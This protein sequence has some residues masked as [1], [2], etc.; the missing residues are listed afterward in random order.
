MPCDPRYLS[1]FCLSSL[2]IDLISGVRVVASPAASPGHR[3]EAKESLYPHE[4][5]PPS[6]VYSLASPAVALLGCFEV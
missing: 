3:P 6:R 1:I 2:M 5:V 4:E